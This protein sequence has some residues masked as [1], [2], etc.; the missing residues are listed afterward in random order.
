[1]NSATPEDG[2]PFARAAA[3]L[4]AKG[5]TVSVEAV[6]MR[7]RN[8]LSPDS[9]CMR[10][11]DNRE[12]TIGDRSRL[13]SVVDGRPLT[14]RSK[15]LGEISLVMKRSKKDVW[16]EYCNISG[17]PTG[18]RHR[19][20][21]DRRGR[22]D[23]T[24]GRKRIRKIIFAH[25]EDEMSTPSSATTSA[26]SMQ[27][28]SA[29]PPSPNETSHP[30]SSDHDDPVVMAP[31]CPHHPAECSDHDD[32][33]VMTRECPSHHP[34]ESSDHDPVVT[35]TLEQRNKALEAKIAAMTL[36][37]M[38]MQQE[39]DHKDTV[40][41]AFKRRYERMTIP[42]MVSSDELVIRHLTPFPSKAA[43]VAFY[44]TF[45]LDV[46][47]HIEVRLI[48]HTRSLVSVLMKTSYVTY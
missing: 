27:T 9:M 43:A 29:V 8:V 39:L 19:G 41:S 17:I 25:G 5:F 18:H 24:R 44:K 12:W 4:N 42:R 38:R 10:S 33:A 40:L 45:V 14:L 3:V 46:V 30:E 28:G 23:D 32:P 36:Q 47:P 21:D 6:R 31:E 48:I 20:I 16:I 35:T 1:M 2:D 15:L 37:I 26:G 34:D 13:M 22:K 7:Y 11:T